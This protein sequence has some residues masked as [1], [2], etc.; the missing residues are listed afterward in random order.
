MTWQ[1]DGRCQS[2]CRFVRVAASAAR[3][4]RRRTLRQPCFTHRFAHA[5]VACPP[6]RVAAVGAAVP[7]GMIGAQ[8]CAFVMEVGEQEGGQSWAAGPFGSRKCKTAQ[9]SR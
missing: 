4:T 9:H 6:V 8:G 3:R 2:P 5:A 1:T 7:A